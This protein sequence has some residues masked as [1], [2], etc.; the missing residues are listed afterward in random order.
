MVKVRVV[1]QFHGD[2]IQAVS[3]NEVSHVSCH[4]NSNDDWQ[5]DFHLARSFDHDDA[6]TDCTP[7]NACQQRSSAQQRKRGRRYSLAEPISKRNASGPAERASNEKGRHEDTR[8]NRHA[9]S[10]C[11]QNEK[12][13]PRDPECPRFELHWIRQDGA[14]CVFSRPKEDCGKL[15]DVAGRTA[16]LVWMELYSEKVCGERYLGRAPRENMATMRTFH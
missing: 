4:N 5:Q 6:Q 7:L 16:K 10:E 11:H 9:K 14:D 15:V 1:V 2:F 3:R 13:C 8:R 12:G